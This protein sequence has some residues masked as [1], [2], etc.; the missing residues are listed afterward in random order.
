ME[1]S[2]NAI[3]NGLGSQS[4]YLV[5]L[6]AE[7]RIPCRYSITADTG[8]EDDCLWS[9]GERSTAREYFD[10]VV[11][12]YCVDH[13]IDARFVRARNKYGKEI[14]DLV[15]HVR[16][17]TAAGKAPA[18]PL[19]GSKGGRL[20]QGCTQ[21]WK[22]VAIHQEAR[23]LGAKRLRTAQGIHF[24]EAARRMKGRFLRDE[25]GWSIYQEVIKF[26]GGY[27]D[28]K[29]CTHFYPL[30]DLRLKREDVRKILT[31]KGIPFLES[32]ECDHCPHKDLP[33][34]QR[35]APDKLVE[36]AALEASFKGEWFFTSERVP[37]LQ[38]I[39][40]MKQRKEAQVEAD[41]GC[42]NSYCGI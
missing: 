37:L 40:Q 18:V 33:R 38:A 5:V 41:F 3:A 9:T 1:M 28:V 16:T 15:T 19:F 7:G 27:K 2:V 12:P 35:T 10:R 31:E 4:M 26:K 17:I 29:W 32:S 11:K 24:G 6:A 30:V 13:G 8:A 21:K 36:I 22:I 25:E 23:R 42:G 34:W 39:E 20:M 14:T